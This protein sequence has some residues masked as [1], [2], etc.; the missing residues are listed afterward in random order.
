M[1]R[2]LFYNFCTDSSPNLET[3]LMNYSNPLEKSIEAASVKHGKAKG[4]L[5]YKFTS[6]A[7]RHVPDRLFI[8]KGH[9]FFIE[10]KRKGEKPTPGQQIEH[11]KMRKHGAIVH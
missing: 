6:P 9:V 3:R 2:G 10:V 11:E 7:Q 1:G 5:T 4:C 8:Y